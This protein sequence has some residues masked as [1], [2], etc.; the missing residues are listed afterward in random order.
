MSIREE[1]V[2]HRYRHAFQLIKKGS[3]GAAAIF[4]EKVASGD[5]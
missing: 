4:E 5:Q 1:E 3:T 2:Q